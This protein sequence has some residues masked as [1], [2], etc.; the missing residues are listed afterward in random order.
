MKATESKTAAQ[1][2]HTQQQ[3]PFFQKDGEGA[4]FGGEQ[5]QA[6]AE[7][8]DFR[9]KTSFDSSEAYTSQ[10]FLTP[11]PIQAKLKVGKPGDRYEQEADKMADQVVQHLSE[12]SPA[13]PPPVNGGNIS[14]IGSSHTQTK[15]AECAKEEQLQKREGEEELATKG[16]ELQRKPIFDSGTDPPEENIQRKPIFESEGDTPTSLQRKCSKCGKETQETP[17][18]AKSQNSPR[19]PTSSLQSRLNASKGKGRPLSNDVRNSMESSFG[20]DFSKV[21]VHTSSEAVQ[22]SQELGAQAFTHGSDIYFSKGKYNTNSDK[23]KHLLAHELTHTVQ[24]GGAIRRAGNDS[25]GE[26]KEENLADIP[27]HRYGKI[28]EDGTSFKIILENFPVKK[29]YDGNKG[30]QTDFVFAD[31]PR[32]GK[33]HENKWKEQIK[34]IVQEQLRKVARGKISG[35]TTKKYRL[36]LVRRRFKNYGLIGSFTELVNLLIRPGWNRNGRPATFQIEHIIDDRIANGDGKADNINNLYLLEASANARLGGIVGP[37]RAAHVNPIL[38]HYKDK[39]QHGNRLAGNFETALANYKI[40]VSSVR[41]K[42][43][44]P[45][46]SYITFDQFEN[47]KTSPIHKKNIEIWSADIPKGKFLLT[48]AEKGAGILLS[49]KHTEY[50][51]R[52]FYLKFEWNDEDKTSGTLNVRRILDEKNLAI[53]DEIER[54][55]PIEETEPGSRTFKA[56]GLSDFIPNKLELNWFS[57]ITNITGTIDNFLD[58]RAE[59]K[60]NPS[61]GLLK[62]LELDFSLVGS[63]IAVEKTFSSSDLKNKFPKPFQLDNAYLTIGVATKVGIYAS[64]GIDFSIPKVGSGS[65]TAKASKNGF[66]FSGTFDFESKIFDEATLTVG[67][68]S[69]KDK[70]GESPW[71]FNG[72]LKTKKDAFKGVE[73][74][75]AIVSFENNIL[76]GTGTV[77][78]TIPGVQG[79]S[80]YVFYDANTG[81]FILKTELDLDDGLPGVKSGKVTFVVTKKANDSEYSLAIGG[82]LEPDIPG[83]RGIKFIVS[84][85]DGI[86]WIKVKARFKKG[87]VEGDITLGLTNQ[88]VDIDGN[89]TGAESKKL[90]PFGKGRLTVVFSDVLQGTIGAKFTADAT[91]DGKAKVLL[92]GEIGTPKTID[93]TK[94]P[95]IDFEKKIIPFPTIE[96]PI[97]AIRVMGKGVGIYGKIG[98]GI[99]L[100]A[101]VGPL[102]LKGLK[103]GLKDFDPE[104]PSTAEVRGDAELD[105]PANAGIRVNFFAGVGVAFIVDVSFKVNGDLLIQLSSNVIGKASL[106]WTKEGGLELIEASVSLEGAVD[107]LLKLSGELDID[108]DLLFKTINLYNKKWDVGEPTKI[109][110]FGDFKFT[111]PLGFKDNKVKKPSH[112][113]FKYTDPDLSSDAKRKAKVEHSMK[114][115]QNPLPPPPPGKEEIIR[116]MKRRPSGFG[117]NFRQKGSI[118]DKNTRYGYLA[119][120]K[121]KYGPHADVPADYKIDFSFVKPTLTPFENQELLRFRDEVFTITEAP[122]WANDIKVFRLIKLRE[123]DESHWFVDKGLVA[124]VAAEIRAGKKEAEKASST[125]E[126]NMSSLPPDDSLSS[127]SNMSIAPQEQLVSEQ[128]TSRELLEQ[129][130]VPKEKHAEPSAVQPKLKIGQPNDQYEQE[131]DTVAD[132]VVNQING[133]EN[134]RAKTGIDNHVSPNIQHKCAECAEK[135]KGQKAEAR[136]EESVQR[137]PIITGALGSTGKGIMRKCAT[138]GKEETVQ[139]KSNG[140]GTTNEGF[141]NQLNKSKGKGAA[142]PKETQEQMGPALGSDLNKVR[143]HTG[144]EASQMNQDLNA[145]AFTHGSDIYFNK[146]NYDPNSKD[147]QHLLAHELTHTVQQGAVKQNGNDSSSSPVSNVSP[148]LQEKTDCEKKEEKKGSK[149][150]AKKNETVPGEGTCIISDRPPPQPPKNKKK[151]KGEPKEADIETKE[152]APVEERQSHAPPP[153]ENAPKGEEDKKKKEE[154]KGPCEMRQDAGEKGKGGKAGG[155]AKGGEKKGAGGAKGENGGEDPKDGAGKDGNKEKG[156]KKEEKGKE[157]ETAFLSELISKPEDTMTDP[158]GLGEAASPEA[159]AER[160]EAKATASG[161]LAELNT[162]RSTV[163]GLGSGKLQFIPPEKNTEDPVAAKAVRKNH[164]RTSAQAF[165]F[166]RAATT[167]LTGFIDK[168][169]LEAAAI[170]AGTEDKKARLRSRIQEKRDMTSSLFAQLRIEAEAKANAAIKQIEA[171][172]LMTL[173]NIE[174]KAMIAKLQ[175]MLT[176]QQS[177]IKLEVAKINQLIKVEQTYKTGYDGVVDVGKRMGDQVIKRAGQHER[178]YRTAEKGSER[179]KKYVG[180]PKK[181]DGF[182][183]GYLT[184]NRWM[185]RADAAKE[186]GEQYRDAFKEEAQKQADNMMC[187]KPKD[188]ETT[189]VIAESSME[190]LGCAKDNALE[191]IAKQRKAALMQAQYAREQIGNTIRNS[192]AATLS[193]L[194]EREHAQLQLINDYGIR[195]E[196]AIE[197]DSERAVGSIIQGV[198]TAA[199]KVLQYLLQ[200]QMSISGAQAPEPKELEKQLRLENAQLEKA[201]SAAKAVFAQTV[202]TTKMSLRDGEEKAMEALEELYYQ[203]EDDG[204]MLASTFDT[205]IKDLQANGMGT[206]E[207]LNTNYNQVIQAETEKA[208]AMLNGV[209]TGTVGVYEQIATGLKTRFEESAAQLEKGMQDSLDKSEDGPNLDQKICAQ[210]EQA[211]SDVQPWWKSVLKVLLIIVVIIVVALVLGPAIIGAVGAAATALAGSLGAGAALAGTIGAW[212]GPIIGGAI[213]GAISGAAI[214]VGNNL[215]DIAGTDKELSW[216]SV[217]K[218]VWGAVIAGAIG[219]ALGGLGGQFAQ[220]LMGRVGA[221]FAVSLSK[222]GIEMAFDVVGGILGDLAAGNP[223][224]WDSI[225]MGLVIG[226]T[227]QISMGGISGLAKARTKPDAPGAPTKPKTK[228]EGLTDK[229]AKSWV[230]KTAEK[231]TDFQGKMMKAG[232]KFGAKAGGIGDKAPSLKATQDA[233]A[234]AR[235]RMDKGEFMPTKGGPEVEGWVKTPDAGGTEG[236]TIPEATEP[237]G[238]APPKDLTDATDIKDPRVQQE[239]D[240]LGG[241]SKQTREMLAQNPKLRHALIENPAAA[242]M[243]KRCSSP[244]FPS[245]AS[246]EDIKALQQM[247]PDPSNQQVKNLN[248]FF[249]DLRNSGIKGGDF[250]KIVKQM[251]SRPDLLSKIVD[252]YSPA[253]FRQIIDDINGNLGSGKGLELVPQ[254]RPTGRNLSSVEDLESSLGKKPRKQDPNSDY[255]Y[256]RGDSR[257]DNFKKTLDNLIDDGRGLSPNQL[258]D[259][260]ANVKGN[261]P[262]PKTFLTDLSNASGNALKHRMRNFGKILEGLSAP[263][264]DAAFINALKY[265][266]TMGGTQ[267][268]GMKSVIKSLDDSLDNIGLKDAEVPEGVGTKSIGDKISNYD[269]LA[270]AKEKNLAIINESQPDLQKF[271]RNLMDSTDTPVKLKTEL[272]KI[273]DADAPDP[274]LGIN[275]YRH[276]MLSKIHE[277][278]A[279]AAVS[280]GASAKGIYDEYINYLNKLDTSVGGAGE[281]FAKKL[282]VVEGEKKTIPI[283]EV[284]GFK[285]FRPDNLQAQ[286][287]KNKSLTDLITKD[288]VVLATPEEIAGLR[289]LDGYDKVKDNILRIDP[290]DVESFGNFF[291]KKRLIIDFFKKGAIQEVKTGQAYKPEQADFY[292]LLL[293]YRKKLAALPLFKD[294]MGKSGFSLKYA[295]MPGQTAP[296][297]KMEI[298]PFKE[299]ARIYRSLTEKGLSPRQF[300]VIVYGRDGIRYKMNGIKTEDRIPMGGGDKS[301]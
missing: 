156:D 140:N 295:V 96:I 76:S 275:D 163:T 34:P 91:G 161:A 248:E 138:C 116:E 229:M 112:E 10:A 300:E 31:K 1:S 239:L 191:D 256:W 14:S 122:W 100:F 144:E 174:I 13:S 9:G 80:I 210:A 205:T 280:P 153:D 276:K 223:I 255:M 142:L 94:T 282:G 17:I 151:P 74:L 30:I 172:H 296:S 28:I 237:L 99:Y 301:D 56:S 135:E 104:N 243:L 204:L 154:P 149:E 60:V 45:S 178:T 125:E 199:F 64:G 261:V 272:S 267:A 68:D 129:K 232:E 46:A 160:E 49:Q 24:Q 242:K 173:V 44:V 6:K 2:S 40:V 250:S 42:I 206:Y 230:G 146:G 168:G 62:G 63:S 253:N 72:K 292:I 286:L 143:V 247:L 48:T 61:L 70:P 238:A 287:G 212:L 7:S 65:I 283:A 101:K 181:K 90:T 20:S 284:E 167:K 111:F 97:F 58:L 233:M 4:F 251:G 12:T 198:N 162:T 5:V 22:M 133:T 246:V 75:S 115:A 157:G 35:S 95:F 103:L 88:A 241:M 236:K 179:D 85:I 127:E 258:A 194:T 139:E 281:T 269:S 21:R 213:V 222:F 226:G 98:G 285:L 221:S 117:L 264:G 180:P 67:Y 137:K 84:Y 124:N 119:D 131:A 183:D 164:T 71:S 196:I 15:C 16:E 29:S 268:K 39:W 257:S 211:A 279:D 57:S 123:F 82:E 202:E 51:S 130:N 195:Q 216:D 177:V 297:V 260:L 214:Q 176:Y 155:A 33:E 52:S 299:G 87:I 252:N 77:K 273:I 11:S 55:I 50:A 102:K 166:M 141:E 132:H 291:K 231:I 203:G 197:R 121:M 274:K 249:Y 207:K 108:L 150:E 23:G 208:K 106:K 120:L 193:Q 110:S 265:L 259:V 118:F 271:L 290:A 47:S 38:D 188:L 294:V 189:L 18:Q 43:S 209:V 293:K 8:G 254:D 107:L 83:I 134:Q 136:K 262:D 184:Y 201:L 185:A 54:S 92:D 200:Y 114:R 41:R 145:K 170:R 217:T 169:Q 105:L 147:G 152:G 175:T 159:L 79:G 266:D 186:V 277:A 240:A 270:N 215:I 235:E 190:S 182:W 73:S 37:L 158:A 224:T 109:G 128:N 78:L 81:Q 220:V 19:N 32:E 93:L 245:Q 89:P 228:I 278:M 244:C 219:G 192:L 148:M 69:S 187:G 25:G 3:Q 53:S 27:T 36:N 66:T 225:V 126:D 59:G 234:N 227:V 289:N 263:P 218:G 26:T 113:D 298:D 171:Q 86:L 165:G 288:T